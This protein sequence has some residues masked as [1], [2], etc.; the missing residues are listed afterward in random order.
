MGR[1]RGPAASEPMDDPSEA[2]SE[3][4]GVDQLS[5]EAALAQLESIVD[6]LERGELAL[7]DALRDFERGVALTRRCAAE[8]DRAE[9]RIEVLVRQGDDF[10]TEPFEAGEDDEAEEED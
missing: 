5:F 6:R 3:P 2:I 4:E 8:L 7:E 1:R 9:R 10:A